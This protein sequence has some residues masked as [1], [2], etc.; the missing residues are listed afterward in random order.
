M[1]R[2]SHIIRTF[3]PYSIIAQAYSKAH[4][5]ASCILNKA[6]S[7]DVQAKLVKLMQT[8]FYILVTGRN[9]DL[10]LGKGNPVAVKNFG[11]NRQN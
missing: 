10:N 4:I 2:L 6:I 1:D 3:F 7:H 9:D 8:L 11:K 5:K